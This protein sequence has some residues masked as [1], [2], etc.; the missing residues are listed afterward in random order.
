MFHWHVILHVHP[1]DSCNILEIYTYICMKSVGHGL[2]TRDFIRKREDGIL[3]MVLDLALQFA[4]TTSVYV[5]AF[6][7]LQDMYQLSA[8]AAALPQ[9]SSFALGVGSW[10]LHRSKK[11][12]SLVVWCICHFFCL[13]ICAQVQ[14]EQPVLQQDWKLKQITFC[15]LLMGLQGYVVRLVGGALVGRQAYVEFTRL[16]HVMIALSVMQLGLQSQP[17]Q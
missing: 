10:A 15:A 12:Q 3:A 13:I 6:V 4:G 5:A 17:K 16:M 1:C 7:S 11:Y 2:S 9:F 8:A 14:L